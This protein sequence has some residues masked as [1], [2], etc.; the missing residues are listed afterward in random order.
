MEEPPGGSS[1]VSSLGDP[2]GALLG[3]RSNGTP[4]DGVDASKVIQIEYDWARIGMTTMRV[5]NGE[6]CFL[7]LHLD[8]QQ[9]LI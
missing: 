2:P 3:S 4:R 7:R 5:R 9:I 6:L 1:I 8:A